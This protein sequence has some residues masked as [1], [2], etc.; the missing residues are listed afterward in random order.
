MNLSILFRTRRVGTMAAIALASA[1][2]AC[3]NEDPAAQQLTSIQLPLETAI[4]DGTIFKLVSA[5]FEFDGPTDTEVV[6]TED[7]LGPWVNVDVEPGSYDITLQ[8]HWELA[9]RGPSSNL[10]GAVLVSPNPQRIEAVEGQT[11]DVIFKFS[12]GEDPLLDGEARVRLGIEVEAPTCG[13]GVLD[14]GEEC[15]PALE[16]QSNEC[17]D[18]CT[19]GDQACS[20]N[21]DCASG[22]CSTGRCDECDRRSEVCHD[23]CDEDAQGSPSFECRSS[24]NQS[25]GSGEEPCRQSCRSAHSTCIAICRATGI[26]C[27]S[28]NN[29]IEACYTECTADV[30]T[31][32]SDCLPPC[33]ASEQSACHNRCETQHDE[34]SEGCSH[35]LTCRDARVCPYH[36]LLQ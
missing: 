8:E 23:D 36:P 3:G 1:L 35:C 11:S 28:C 25:C 27:G 24:C 17:D 13:N 19:G 14:P 26:G 9:G 4:D 16:G 2:P 22:A 6:I 5:V 7:H 21:T 18:L 12:F 15:D 29:S 32:A 20:A 33:S 10:H 30:D 31:C 34:C